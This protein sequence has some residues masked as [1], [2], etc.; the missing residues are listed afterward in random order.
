MHGNLS[1]L[2]CDQGE[3]LKLKERCCKCVLPTA[4]NQYQKIYQF[5]DVLSRDRHLDRP[6]YDATYQVNKILK[7]T[8][9]VTNCTN[10]S[11]CDT[12]ENP[13]LSY[14]L[15]CYINFACSSLVLVG[16]RSP[17]TNWFSMPFVCL[18]LVTVY[19]AYRIL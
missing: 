16:R 4:M 5:Y 11:L 12:F 15:K 18:S 13:K 9:I 19:T 2:A 1:A 10:Y 8:R 14:K 3:L 17:A 7:Q 6:Y